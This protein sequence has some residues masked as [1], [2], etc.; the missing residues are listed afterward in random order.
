MKLTIIRVICVL[1][2]VAAVGLYAYGVLVNGEGPTDNLLRTVI[3]ALSGVS[4]LMKTFPKRRSLDAYASAYEKHLGNAFADDLK[5]RES[6]LAAV[7]LFDENKYAQAIK[8]LD[9]LKMDARTKA[10]YHALYLFIGLCQTNL[11]LND[12]AIATYEEAVQRGAV[13]STLYS[14]LGARYGA[15][16]NVPKALEAYSQAIDLD[17][18]NPMPHSNIAN[19]AI[20]HGQYDVVIEAGSRALEL[21]PGLYQAA[22][23]M[24]MAYAALGDEAQRE[25]YFNLAVKGGQDAKLLQNACNQYALKAETETAAQA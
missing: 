20:T 9:T 24:A 19:L 25:K 6:L 18:E 22:S 15:V 21:D 3:I 23:A 11:G 4:A 12:A 2:I 7:R 1:L 10:D 16:N 13:S 8:A 14:N 17:P 5:K